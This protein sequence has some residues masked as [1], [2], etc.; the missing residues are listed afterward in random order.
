M[1]NASNEKKLD[2][3]G[4]T[5]LGETI[6]AASGDEGIAR[7]NAMYQA[8]LRRYTALQDRYRLLKAANRQLAEEVA[9]LRDQCDDFALESVSDALDTTELEP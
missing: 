8:V 9:W 1:Q 6:A 3:I 2:P 5:A 4:L 7:I